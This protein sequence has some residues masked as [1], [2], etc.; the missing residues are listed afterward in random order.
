MRACLD[1]QSGLYFAISLEFKIV[2]ED[3]SLAK[4]TMLKLS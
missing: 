1:V 3:A 2:S 4:P